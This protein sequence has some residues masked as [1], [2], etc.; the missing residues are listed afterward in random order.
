MEMSF[1]REARSEGHAG[2]KWDANQGLRCD[3]P[4]R[5]AAKGWSAQSGRDMHACNQPWVTANSRAI[6]GG[7]VLSSGTRGNSHRCFGSAG[8]RTRRG[9]GRNRS[10][11]SRAETTYWPMEMAVLEI[12]CIQGNASRAGL[13]EHQGITA[14]CS[15]TVQLGDKD[16]A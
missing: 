14:G 15:S 3:G 12:W 16:V 7:K 2:E 4:D 1:Y 13:R 11:V 10:G 6:S 8:R 9:S 5:R